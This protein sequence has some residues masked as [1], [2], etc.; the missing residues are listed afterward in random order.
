MEREEAIEILS[1]ELKTISSLISNCETQDT[2]ALMY[3]G[4]DCI[5]KRKEAIEKAISALKGQHLH[6][7]KV[8]IMEGATELLERDTAKA[9]HVKINDEIVKIGGITFGRGTKAYRCPNCKRLVIYR[10]R[11]CR[12]CGQRLKWEE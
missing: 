6:C 1:D 10:D 2:Y 11:F 5:R 8:L 7:D 3:R 4:T 9:P 12:D